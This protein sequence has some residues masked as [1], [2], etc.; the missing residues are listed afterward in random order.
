MGVLAHICLSRDDQEAIRY[1]NEPATLEDREQ[2][3]SDA[4]ILNQ[5]GTVKRNC[6]LNRYYLTGSLL[7]RSKRWASTLFSSAATAPRSP[8]WTSGRVAQKDSAAT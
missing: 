6:G 1:A 4:S 7:P 3:R 2:G 8:T 5:R